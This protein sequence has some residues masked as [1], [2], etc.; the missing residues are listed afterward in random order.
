[1]QFLGVR[2]MYDARDVENPKLFRAIRKEIKDMISEGKYN[3][4][5]VSGW[6]R[7]YKGMVSKQRKVLRKQKQE[8]INARKQ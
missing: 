8:E 4:E 3:N 7:E 1:M 5:D 6:E 2:I